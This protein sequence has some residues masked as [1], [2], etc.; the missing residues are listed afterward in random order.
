M[1]SE[2]GTNDIN[3]VIFDL[4]GVLVDSEQWWDEIRCGLAS[5]HNLPWP[6]D[7]TRLMQGMST[8]EWSAYLSNS[9]GIP[10]DANEIAR[11]VIDRMEA[12]YAQRL[13]VIDGA[14][15]A[16]SEIAARWPVGI[17]SSSPRVLIDTVLEVAQLDD[18]VTASLSTEQVRAG[19]P[20][21]EVYTRV[22]ELLG[23]DP[24]RTV[25]IEDSSNGLRSA[26]AAGLIV[27]A[28]PNPTYPPAPDAIELADAI[29][30][31]ISL[32]TPAMV[33]GLARHASA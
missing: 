13:P 14:I 8:A 2:S 10:G 22:A 29:L 28:I 21:P 15:E 26:H 25:G 30:A 23:V 5:E 31:D 17:A 3:A 24:V 20:S 7:A 32:L 12:R 19:K 6:E 16:V 4:D 1:T 11:T 18:V 33:D 27:V 9:V